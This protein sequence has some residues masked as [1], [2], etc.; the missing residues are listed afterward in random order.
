[1]ENYFITKRDDDFD[2]MLSP[3]YREISKIH[4]TPIAVIEK[5]SE[6]LNAHS[7]KNLLD[8]GSGVG[9]FCLSAAKNSKIHFTGIEL[10][11]ELHQQAIE[12]KDKMNLTN[13]KFKQSDIVEVPFTT[14]DAIYYYQPFC[15]HLCEAEWIEQDQEFSE[16]QFNQYESYVINELENCISGTLF[17]SYCANKIEMPINFILTDMKFDGSLQLWIKK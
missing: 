16:E 17:I 2:S 13:V 8:I 6:W 5:V 9:K 12:L 7:V 1:M 15:E 11:E 4:W 3:Y 10:R 14:Y